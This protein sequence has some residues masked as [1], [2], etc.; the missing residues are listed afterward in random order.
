MTDDQ[1]GW[2]LQDEDR[3][4]LERLNKALCDLV[5]L[6]RTGQDL[7]GIGEAV[8][9]IECLLEGGNIE[10][11]VGLDVGFRRGTGSDEGGLFVCFHISEDEIILNEL[12]TTYSSDIGSDHFN[13]GYATLDPNGHFDGDGIERWLEQLDEVKSYEDAKLDVSR[14]HV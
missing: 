3:W 14:D 13:N 12:H 9:G 4:L 8:D 5:P 2:S 1:D 11:S 10:I 7:I 6:A